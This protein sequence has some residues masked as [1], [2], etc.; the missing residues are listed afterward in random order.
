MAAERIP[1]PS[2]IPPPA[3]RRAASSAA[4]MTRSRRKGSK[5]EEEQ[6]QEESVTITTVK[7][8]KPL[9]IGE[10]ERQNLVPEDIKKDE[11]V[12]LRF[13]PVL[14]AGYKSPDI[15][16]LFHFLLHPEWIELHC[17]S[18]IT[19]T[20]SC[21]Q[22]HDALN[23]YEKREGRAASMVGLRACAVCTPRFANREDPLGAE[24]KTTGDALS[25]IVLVAVVRLDLPMHWRLVVRERQDSEG[26]PRQRATK[27]YF[28][29]DE[30]R[31]NQCLANFKTSQGSSRLS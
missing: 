25:S 13:Q 29:D 5:Q 15:S 20:S 8:V 10:L 3:R 28:E 7:P 21:R 27:L 2:S 23:Q 18:C 4:T 1:P 24:N 17:S 22:A 26:A 14:N 19:P 9:G 16:A 30:E 31:S 12:D 6:Q 11:R